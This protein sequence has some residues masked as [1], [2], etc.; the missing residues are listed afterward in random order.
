M[1]AV[2][3]RSLAVIGLGVLILGAVLYVAS[4]VDGRAPEVAAIT[5]TQPLPDDAT[6]ALIT[7]SI[8]VEFTEPVDQA[9]AA[10]ALS[11]EPS[12]DGGISWSGS[13]MIF[14]PSDALEP[15]TSYRVSLGGGIRDLAGNRMTALAEPFV[16][17]TAGPPTVIL[18]EPAD[19]ADDVALA[20]PITITF[21]SPMDTASVEAALV[22]RPAFAHELRW[23]GEVL[24]IVPVDP[25]VA[26]QDYRVVIGDDAQDVAGVGLAD[27]LTLS[28][29][30]IRPGLHTTLLVPADG[31]DG[32]APATSIAVFFDAPIDPD[33]VSADALSL[34]PDVAGTLALVDE[35]GEEPTN[36]AEATALRFSP[37]GPLPA[38]TTFEVVLDSGVTSLDAGGLAAPTRWSFTTGPA[39]AALSNRIAFLSDRGGIANL[40][41]MNPDGSAARQVS[42]ELTPVLDYA[43]AP[44]GTSFVVGDGRRLVLAHASGGDRQILT[45]EGML[46]FDPAYSPDGQT[47]AF[48]RAD[49]ESGQGLGLWERSAAGGAADR[50]AVEADPSTSSAAPSGSGDDDAVQWLRAPRYAPDGS[51]IAF[52]DVTGSVGILELGMDAVRRVAYEAMA[53]PAWLPDSD[54]VLVTGRS[55]GTASPERRFEAPIAPLGPTGR[56][57]IAILDRPGASLLESGLGTGAAVVAIAADGRVAYARADGQLWIADD[58]AHAGSPAPGLEDERIEAASFAPGEESMVVVVSDDEA[59]ASRVRIE[60]LT[61]PSGDRSILSNEGRMARWLP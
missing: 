24:E 46:E 36:P 8:E 16:F 28:F 54:A 52:V 20:G 59:A 56:S 14:T 12:V 32:I 49:A 34:V 7:T 29:R 43:V 53:P 2:V 47:I 26:D 1:R 40:W 44:D 38:S 9:S 10:E 15:A 19:G 41:V 61:L 42:S 3:L 17:E 11:I 30:T 21:S 27:P 33:S 50:I 23:D 4:T 35:T 57:E 25:L 60:R 6:R 13:T 48:A 39:L 45:P 5:V 55:S 58:P 51:A 31:T 18:T 22:L 37:S